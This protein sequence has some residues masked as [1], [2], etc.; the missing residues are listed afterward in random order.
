M[1]K[2]HLN[3]YDW[4]TLKC[5]RAVKW[6]LPP[7]ADGLWN[8]PIFRSS[9]SSPYESE[10]CNFFSLFAITFWRRV[11]KGKAL[12]IHLWEHTRTS[13]RITFLI[14]K[15]SPR[16]PWRLLEFSWSSQYFIR[17][18]YSS[19]KSWDTVSLAVLLHFKANITFCSLAILENNLGIWGLYIPSFCSAAESLLSDLS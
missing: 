3:S 14:L 6:L 2:S 16:A 17:R 15:P 4:K 19:P 9:W 8:S 13:E 10:Q 11:S 5:H 1:A 7:T 12:E 18:C